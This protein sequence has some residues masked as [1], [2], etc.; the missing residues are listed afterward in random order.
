MVNLFLL[1]A[2]T[3]VGLTSLVQVSGQQ[4]PQRPQQP[5]QPP[6]RF[7]LPTQAPPVWAVTLYKDKQGGGE[8]HN[9]TGPGCRPVPEKFND[10]TSSLQ[11]TAGCVQLFKDIDCQNPL[12]TFTVNDIM[13]ND[14]LQDSGYNDEVS[15]VGECGAPPTQPPG[16]K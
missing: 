9:L 8:S 1:T 14:N 4:Q 10:E 13:R 15:S 2:V 11:V 7:G 5:R 6:R 12:G 16:G 3:L